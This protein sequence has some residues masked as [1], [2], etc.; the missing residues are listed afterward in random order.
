MSSVECE[1]INAFA[2]PQD[3]DAVDTEASMAAV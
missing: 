3:G 2:E 1:L